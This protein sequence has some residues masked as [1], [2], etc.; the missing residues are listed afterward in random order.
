MRHIY[1]VLV[2]L[3]PQLVLAQPYFFARVLELPGGSVATA[4]EALMSDPITELS[5]NRSQ[6]AW[7]LQAGS[8]DCVSPVS[9]Y[10]RDVVQNS[11]YLPIV[12]PSNEWTVKHYE[13]FLISR[14]KYR[15]SPDSVLI[16]GKHHYE[17]TY[18]DSFYGFK[19]TGRY[20]RE[21]NG[22]VYTS[23]GE[24][25]YNLNLGTNDTLPSNQSANQG[26]RTVLAL[27]TAIFDD[28]LPRKTMTVQCATDPTAPPVT[29]VEGIGDMQIFFHSEVQC[30]NPLD[31][32][33]DYIVCYSVNG[34]IVYMKPDENCDLSSTTLPEK[35]ALASVFPN[36]TADWLYIDIPVNVTEPTYQVRIYSA[37]G[38]CTFSPKQST[39]DGLLLIDVSGLNPGS[40]WGVV[41]GND[42]KAFPFMF[43]KKND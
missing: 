7:P 29:V 26:A 12:S 24:V 36:P 23:A 28:S 30:I 32:P 25:V 15:F 27:G 19:A 6:K 17:L 22:I 37:L 16:N 42:G 41:W 4:G 31:G 33:S 35:R 1:I 3:F 5:M 14:R 38:A 20:Y 39:A 34:E 2:F 21:E 10:F 11:D 8:N 43:V 9:G 40:Y 18:T 13:L